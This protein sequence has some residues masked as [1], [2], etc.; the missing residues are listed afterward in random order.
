M[1]AIG[2]MLARYLRALFAPP[3]KCLVLDLDNTLWG[4]VLGEEGIG[5]IA[6][7]DEYPGSVFKAFQRQLQSYRDRGILLAIASK[8][9]ESEVLELFANHP[10]LVLRLEDFAAR[11]INWNDKATSLPPSPTS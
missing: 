5:G 1:I 4:G 2:G 8:N 7:G 10:D 9:N 6:L 3:C 11:Q